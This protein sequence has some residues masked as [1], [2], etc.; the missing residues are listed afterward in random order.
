MTK[1]SHES[2]T[3]G[4][5]QS[6]SVSQEL[7]DIVREGEEVHYGSDTVFSPKKGSPPSRED[8]PAHAGSSAEYAA[9]DNITSLCLAYS[10]EPGI[11]TNPLDEA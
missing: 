10:N 7:E 1:T 11:N 3:P 5:R 9:S 8:F 2:K 6:S 4:G